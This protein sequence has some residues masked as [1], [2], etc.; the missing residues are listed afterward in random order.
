M[1]KIS[2]MGSNKAQT[3]NTKC[4]LLLGVLGVVLFY[5][6]PLYAQSAGS[7]FLNDEIKKAEQIA[8]MPQVS[9][10]DKHAAL[11]K[12]ARLLQLSGN[13]E[14]AAIAWTD[15]AFAEPGKR[16]DDALLESAYCYIAIGEMEKAEVSIKTVM[17]TGINSA[18]LFN[19]RYL[20]AQLAAFKSGDIALLVNLSRDPAYAPYKP[21]M[22]YTLWKVT[23]DARYRSSL[24]AEYPGSPESLITNE[25]QKTSVLSSAMWLLF[26]EQTAG[27]PV[28]QNRQGDSPQPTAG[29]AQS[30]GTSAAQPAPP[31][32]SLPQSH[33]PV[34]LSGIVLQAGLFGLEENAREF[35][36]RLKTAGF[37][38]IPQQRNV[39][40]RV[41][42]AA[43]VPAG[44]D[45]N[46]TIR[47][48][49]QK[50]FESFP[51]NI[52]YIPRAQTP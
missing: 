22:Y 12:L 21:A 29:K 16:D 49:K 28:A 2:P 52:D 30:D 26:S 32:S 38:A 40:G 36:V 35:A 19:A 3:P 42:W 15:A 18:S 24:L 11:V 10:A 45:I 37:D 7:T 39:N 43:L 41:Y 23:G 8:Q 6:L 13:I 17:I 48:L 27:S 1:V 33:P 20:A 44:A 9:G 14:K 25:G 51:V 47:D 50:G 4:L 31:S 34:S 46:R 5:D